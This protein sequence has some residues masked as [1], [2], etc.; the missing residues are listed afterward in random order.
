MLIEGWP[1]Q[2]RPNRFTGL[3]FMEPEKRI[4]Q[5]S[6]IR[7]SSEGL[8]LDGLAVRYGE[9]AIRPFGRERFEPGAFGDLAEA[10]IILNA[11]HKRDRPLARTGGGGLVLTDSREAL[12]FEATMPETREATDTHRLVSASVM[13]GSSVEF[14]ARRERNISGVRVIQS[15]RLFAIGIVDRPSYPSALVDARG[16]ALV[17]ILEQGIE[18]RPGD[19]AAT[20]EA[21]AEAG[22]IDVSTLRG[23]L[24][25]EIDHPPFE[26]LRGFA[27]VLDIPAD[28]L[29]SAAVEDGANEADYTARRNYQNRLKRRLAWL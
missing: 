16:A 17:E 19:R 28:R 6:E 5:N 4:F 24:R 13:R 14:I 3:K 20:L 25:G 29:I 23:I 18:A 26:R 21:L 12:R 27:R 22:G 9:I 7:A 2:G 11:S 10:D 8:I 15:A 1:G